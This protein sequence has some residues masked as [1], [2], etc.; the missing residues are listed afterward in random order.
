MS[1]YRVRV[2]GLA[3]GSPREFFYSNGDVTMTGE[4][5][6][7]LTYARHSIWCKK[8]Q[9]LRNHL[10]LVNETCME[11]FER[12]SKYLLT[13]FLAKCTRRYHLTNRCFQPNVVEQKFGSLILHVKQTLFAREPKYMYMYINMYHGNQSTVIYI[14][15]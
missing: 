9:S 7:N 5:Q 10:S 13:E 11:V 2:V 3:I 1:D 6:Q 4:M 12:Y 15:F 8:L 14:D